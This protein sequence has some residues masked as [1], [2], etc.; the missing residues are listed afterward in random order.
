MTLWKIV[1]FSLRVRNLTMSFDWLSSQ[2][3]REIVQGKLDIKYKVAAVL[4]AAFLFF[5]LEC[6]SDCI[7]ALRA[8]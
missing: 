8:T 2:K 4:R 7:G 1:A 5:R 6:F 3:L